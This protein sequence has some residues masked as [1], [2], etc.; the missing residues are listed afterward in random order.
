[1][2]LHDGKRRLAD[3]K[4]AR[5][6][7]GHL[8]LERI[9]RAE[10]VVVALD[11][12]LQVICQ[13]KGQAAGQLAA[14]LLRREA[15]DVTRRKQHVVGKGADHVLQALGNVIEFALDKRLVGKL[16][17]H[18]VETDALAKDNNLSAVIAGGESN[19]IVDLL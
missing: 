10:L 3:L 2:L 13:D 6:D 16:V 7:E 18:V 19:V 5:V 8:V 1:M 9:G 4:L 12:E 17:G 11:G 14:E 15:G